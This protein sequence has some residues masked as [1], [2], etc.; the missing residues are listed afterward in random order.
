M[1]RAGDISKQASPFTD[2]F[3]KI[4]DVDAVLGGC[5]AVERAALL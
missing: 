1:W 3:W 5:C 2:E 4:M